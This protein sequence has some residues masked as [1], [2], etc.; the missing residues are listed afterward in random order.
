MTR[1][2]LETIEIVTTL[3][4]LKSLLQRVTTKKIPSTVDYQTVDGSCVY[5][6]NRSV[7]GT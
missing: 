4:R 1:A 6:K 7:S 3:K 5:F 2:T